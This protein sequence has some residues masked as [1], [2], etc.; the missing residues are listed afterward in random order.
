MFNRPKM[1]VANID[2]GFVTSELKMMSEKDK[3]YRLPHHLHCC[4]LDITVDRNIPE[5]KK[6]LNL[7]N[8]L[9]IK[10]TLID[11]LYMRA[12]GLRYNKKELDEL[13]DI[14]PINPSRK[15]HHH[16]DRGCAARVKDDIPDEKRYQTCS[17]LEYCDFFHGKTDAKKYKPSLA[18]NLHLYTASEKDA[19]F[20]EQGATKKKRM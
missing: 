7:A 15:I 20:T 2:I 13:L 5:I 4:L 6:L 8:T 1:T 12:V 9:G 18:K 17:L 16:I 11:Q 10:E 14:C 3:K 19:L